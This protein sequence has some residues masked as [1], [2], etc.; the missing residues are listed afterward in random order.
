MKDNQKL[1]YIY[2]FA[3]PTVWNLFENEDHYF[4]NDYKE[5]GF[6]H[7]A[8]KHQLEKVMERHY[9]GK[10]VKVLKLDA[11]KMGDE[12]IIEASTKGELYPHIY[13]A[14]KKSWILSID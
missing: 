10:E 6:I 8:F 13:G 4:P 14:I 11:T 2:H 3:I 1:D 9:E 7:C 12:L 5:E